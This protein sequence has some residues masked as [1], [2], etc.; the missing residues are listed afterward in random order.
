MQP[1]GTPPGRDP[2]LWRLARRRARFKAHLL[3]YLLV[4]AGLWVLWA[5]TGRPGRGLPWPVFVSGFW[6]L[7]LLFEGLAA[8][9]QWGGSL[10]EREYERL[11]RRP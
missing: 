5:L 9:S 3:T 2:A 6:G 1:Y 10:A 8:Y 4:N 7:G 11:M